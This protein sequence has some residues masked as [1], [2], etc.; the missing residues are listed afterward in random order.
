MSCGWRTCPSTIRARRGIFLSLI[1]IFF[2]NAIEASI[3]LP[4]DKRLI[5]VYMDMKN[6]QLYISFT[7]FTA[8][9]KDVYKRQ[10][11]SLFS[12]MTS[13]R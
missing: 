5:R 9:K 3:K 7:N 11:R 6:T 1:H 4:E 13:T 8:G 10:A 2:D 12:R